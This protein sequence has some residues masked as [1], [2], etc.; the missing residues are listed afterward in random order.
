MSGEHI[1]ELVHIGEVEIEQILSG[2]VDKPIDYNQDHDE[3]VVLLQGAA[4]L[5]VDGEMMFLEPGDWVLLPRRTPH[6]LVQTAP[7]TNWLA[8]HVK[9]P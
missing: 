9:A 7:E 3:W 5:E 2:V 1:E 8:V 6:R 4:E